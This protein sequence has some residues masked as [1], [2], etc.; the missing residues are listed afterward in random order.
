MEQY[1][2]PFTITNE[3]LLLVGSISEKIGRIDGSNALGARPRLRRSNQIRSIHSTLLIE[4][5]SLSFGQV[6]D[7]TVKSAVIHA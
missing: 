3:M 7:V 4:A 1:A 6:K 5:N 2:P